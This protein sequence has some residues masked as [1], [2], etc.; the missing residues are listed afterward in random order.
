MSACLPQLME[1]I[2]QCRQVHLPSTVCGDT[3]LVDMQMGQRCLHH[4]VVDLNR[5]QQSA[6]R[7]K[8]KLINTHSAL[9]SPEFNWNDVSRLHRKLK[10]ILHLRFGCSDGETCVE[11]CVKVLAEGGTKKPLP[12]S[13]LN[14]LIWNAEEPV[15]QVVR[16]EYGTSATTYLRTCKRSATVE[17]AGVPETANEFTLESMSLRPEMKHS[18]QTLGFG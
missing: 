11:E 14:Y 12:C 7:H 8:R 6:I 3:T 1:P 9:D 18:E 4:I 10:F 17:R 5:A 16:K 15:G 13:S 2:P